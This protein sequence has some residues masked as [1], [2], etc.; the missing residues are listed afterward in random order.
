MTSR[1]GG[2]LV[3]MVAALTV[4][5]CLGMVSTAEAGGIPY[6]H[7]RAARKVAVKDMRAIARDHYLGTD[8]A[9]AVSRPGTLGGR[10]E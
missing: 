2:G 5:L 6:L 7:K 8:W 9:P 1:E 10:A 3:R 4:C